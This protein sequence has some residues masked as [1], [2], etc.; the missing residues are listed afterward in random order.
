MALLLA[1]NS[2]NHIRKLTIWPPISR[3]GPTV[4]EPPFVVE[5]EVRLLSDF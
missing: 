1:W 4:I 5:M 2:P 3:K